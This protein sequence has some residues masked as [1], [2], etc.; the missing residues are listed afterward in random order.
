MPPPFSVLGDAYFLA[1]LANLLG[2][3]AYVVLDLTRVSTGPALSLT[4]VILA[5]VFVADAFLYC[6]V[7]RDPGSSCSLRAWRR[8]AGTPLERSAEA[9]NVVSSAFYCAATV[10]GLTI[11]ADDSSVYILQIVACL[12][13]VVEAALYTAAWRTAAAAEVAARTT[14]GEPPARA[15]CS[16]RVVY[17]SA[18]ALNVFA[19][20]GYAC[21]AVATGVL[22]I[23][24]GSVAALVA[25]ADG[26]NHGSG[27]LPSGMKPAVG[28]FCIFLD[29]SYLLSACFFTVAWWH[30][31]TEA[32]GA[33][34]KETSRTAAASADSRADGAG[35]GAAPATSGAAAVG[36][37]KSGFTAPAPAQAE[38]AMV[39]ISAAAT[40]A[41]TPLPGDA[42]A[43]AALHSQGR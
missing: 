14:T 37:A 18:N 40:T 30:E 38:A 13:F 10:A 41:S 29:F 43:L 9:V 39:A 8:G 35:G 7:W 28:N 15:R 2:S 21:C 20:S 11:A 22:L 31:A 26:Y 36:E 25:N 12:L 27:R 24:A 34:E 4:Y 3:L 5:S 32:A 17:L 42:P 23:E 1:T 16:P 19:A 6:A 33:P